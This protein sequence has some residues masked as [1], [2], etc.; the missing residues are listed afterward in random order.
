MQ[1]RYINVNF[2]ATAERKRQALEDVRQAMRER[3]TNTSDHDIEKFIEHLLASGWNSD[4]VESY[5]KQASMSGHAS[6]RPSVEA[7]MFHNEHVLDQVFLNQGTYTE[8]RDTAADPNYALRHR[9]QTELTLRRLTPGDLLMLEAASTYSGILGEA[10]EPSTEQ[11]DYWRQIWVTMVNLLHPVKR[12]ELGWLTS[13]DMAGAASWAYKFSH[14]SMRYSEYDYMWFRETFFEPRSRFYVGTKLSFINERLS[15]GFVEA[16]QIHHTEHGDESL[17]MAAVVLL[18]YGID[19]YAR[20]VLLGERVLRA[21][22]TYRSVALRVPALKPYYV[23]RSE[24]DHA[25]QE[26]QQYPASDSL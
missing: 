19:N 23:Y 20:A 21:G 4:D 14:N 11:S 12:T 15:S 22:E 24:A 18:C 5:N 6:T 7:F 16:V 3:F 26:T 17:A 2:G 25:I 10:D 1:R 13:S 8:F 9:G